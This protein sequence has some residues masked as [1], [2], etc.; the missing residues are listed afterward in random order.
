MP[1]TFVDK[2]RREV[3]EEQKKLAYTILEK[4]FGKCSE[5][6]KYVKENMEIINASVVYAGFSK[7]N[8]K[9]EIVPIKIVKITVS[10][11]LEKYEY[12]DCRRAAIKFFELLVPEEENLLPCPFCGG[13]PELHES[14][15]WGGIYTI[16]CTGCGAEVGDDCCLEYGTDK[17]TAIYLWN[18]RVSK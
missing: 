14:D 4:A 6:T 10:K 16:F 2:Y 12:T 18:R 15:N 13:I 11:G 17:E 3:A 1:P 5:F 7:A 9:L 8:V